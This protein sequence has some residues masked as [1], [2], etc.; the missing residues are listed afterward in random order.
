MASIVRDATK[1]FDE[2]RT[3]RRRVAE[4]GG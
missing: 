1:A 2:R 4:L 3:L